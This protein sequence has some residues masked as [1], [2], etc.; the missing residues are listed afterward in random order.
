MNFRVGQQVVC[1]P[2]S[3]GRRYFIYM[4]RVV[5]GNVP[6]V[7]QVYTVRG[8]DSSPYKGLLLQE[9]VSDLLDPSPPWGGEVGFDPIRFKP[10]IK[11]TDISVFQKMLLPK[12][13]KVKA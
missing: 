9:I 6:V 4:G 8:Y 12:K 13:S 3:T 7:G 2:A 1:I 10:V 11:Q 5:Q